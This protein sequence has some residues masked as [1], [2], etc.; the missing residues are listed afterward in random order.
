M[1]NPAV[2]QSVTGNGGTGTG[3]DITA[4]TTGNGLVLLVAYNIYSGGTAKPTLADSTGATWSAD[5]V[6]SP[7]GFTNDWAGIAMFSLPNVTA[8]VAHDLVLTLANGYMYWCV[9]EVD[10]VALS[11]IL[12]QISN[13]GGSTTTVD[14]IST[15]MDPTDNAIDIIFGVCAL[16]CTTSS[17]SVGLTDPPSGYTSL[18]VGQIPTNGFAFEMCY[19]VVTSIGPY[20]AEWTWT[21]ASSN[22]YMAGLSSYKGLSAGSAS[23]CSMALMGVGT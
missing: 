21:T 6:V 7:F 9:C 22:A 3:P 18:Y 20:N 23:A 15:G 10:N 5:N 19:K 12:D 4:G 11:A 17:S 16:K 1:A 14:L 2:V 8:G 13:A